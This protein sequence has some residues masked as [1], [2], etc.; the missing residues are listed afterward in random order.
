MSGIGG[1]SHGQTL[2]DLDGHTLE[3]LGDYL[4]RDRTPA[5]PSIDRSPGCQL[6][7]AA[8]ER[9]RRLTRQAL[10]REAAEEE[11]RNDSWIPRVLDFIGREVRAGR[12]I[13]FDHDGALGSLT[14]TEG[15]VRGLVREAGDRLG[16]IVLGRIVLQGDVTVPGEPITI[17]VEASA[18][19][20]VS[21]VEA[22][23]R[24]REAVYEQLAMH[25]ELRVVAVDVAVHDISDPRPDHERPE[26]PGASRPR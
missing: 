4:D 10:D 2:D 19:W 26:E 23:D 15:A 3:D 25:T 8:L 22:S 20:G 21:I 13:P 5:D 6:A 17:E 1:T 9:L 12:D 16:G 7:L 24:V 18:L 14:I 11:H